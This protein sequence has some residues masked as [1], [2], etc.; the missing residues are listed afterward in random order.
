MLERLLERDLA[1]GGQVMSL[2]TAKELSREFVS[3]FSSCSFFYANG[4]FP[5]PEAYREG[6]WAGSWDPVTRA[7]FDTGVVGVDNA[8]AGLLWIEDED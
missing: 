6:G 8:H 7:T 4:D 3:L 1:Y 2:A 5:P